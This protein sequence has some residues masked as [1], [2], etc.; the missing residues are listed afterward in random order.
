MAT[1]RQTI[2]HLLEQ[3][4]PLDV[5]ARAMFGEYGL[6]CDDRFVGLVCDDT[7][8]LKPTPV[9]EGFAQGEPYPSAKPHPIVDAD[10]LEDPDRLRELFAA[11]AEALPAPKPKRPRSRRSAS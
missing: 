1:S 5:R 10:A 9:T 6:Y 2:D 7:V 3:L 8:Y 4:A 11:T